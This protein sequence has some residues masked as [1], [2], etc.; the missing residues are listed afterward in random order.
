MTMCENW[1]P[2]KIDKDYE[3]C[4][5]YP[6][7]IRKIKTGRIVKE[8]QAS[9]GYIKCNLNRKHYFKHKIIATQF[10]PNPNGH[11]VV[12]HINRIRTDNRIDNLRWV[13]LS[14]NNKNKTSHKGVA[15]TII[16]YDDEPDDLIP[17]DHYGN[18]I[19]E[20][21]YYYS[22]RNNRFYLD[23]GV[24][25]RELPILTNKKGLAFVMVT[26]VNKK[27]AMICFNKFK[28]MYGFI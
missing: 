10:I 8:H 26:N 23:T 11:T 28:R 7:Q 17:V 18:H 24:N 2:C 5:S 14:D 4:D 19:I 20:D 21:Y 9:S 13:S 22:P 6:H 1:V 15:Y 25:L 16:N 27:Q 12:D 3:I